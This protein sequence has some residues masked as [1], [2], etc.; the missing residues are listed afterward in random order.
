MRVRPPAE[1]NVT[2]L[3]PRPPSSQRWLVHPQ[4]RFAQDGAVQLK[5]TETSNDY[6]TFKYSNIK[7]NSKM[8]DTTF[9]LKI[10]KDI[11]VTK[12]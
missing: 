11:H 10:P 5:A 4:R 12:L 1:A 6:M 3:K 7:M 9:D 8:S 2:W